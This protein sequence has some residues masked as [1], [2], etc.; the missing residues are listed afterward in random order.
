M[1]RSIKATMATA[2]SSTSTRGQ[3]DSV[4]KSTSDSKCR[5]HQR[6]S[7]RSTRPDHLHRR[8][9][10]TDLMSSVSN[11]SADCPSISASGVSMTRCRKAGRTT[12]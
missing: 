5:R 6:D 1:N 8:G 11:A 9:T 12:S 4:T 2:A 7:Q 10:S 3:T